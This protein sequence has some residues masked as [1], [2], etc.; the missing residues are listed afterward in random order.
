MRNFLL[1]LVLLLAASAPWTIQAGAYQ[2]RR[3]TA[4]A[5]SATGD[6]ITIEQGE[7]GQGQDPQWQAIK[8]L[9]QQAGNSSR[10]GE[11]T[12]TR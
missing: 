5:M 10:A 6:P 2:Y 3:L 8:V 1:I 4:P 7:A 9:G 12:P 11:G